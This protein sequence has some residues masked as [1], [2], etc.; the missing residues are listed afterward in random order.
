MGDA[1]L[2]DGRLS[3]AIGIL[4]PLVSEYPYYYEARS[5]LIEAYIY[6]GL[7]QYSNGYLSSAIITWGKVLDVDPGNSKAKRYIEQAKSEMDK[8]RGPR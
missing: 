6:K 2:E 8:I 4:A 1:R 5:R 7:D 3:D